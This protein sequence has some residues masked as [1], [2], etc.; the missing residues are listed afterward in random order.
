RRPPDA[1]DRPLLVPLDLLPRA[2]R[3]ALRDRLARPRLRDRRGPRAP[4]READLAAR[5]RTPPRRDR[6]EADAPPDSARMTVRERAAGGD[7]VGALVLF[8]GRGANENDL[9]PLLDVLDPGRRFD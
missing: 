7:A 1:G 4:G 6:T 5:V 2:E 8:H 9:F 3:R